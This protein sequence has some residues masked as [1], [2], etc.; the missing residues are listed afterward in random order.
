M[1]IYP[2]IETSK[3]NEEGF[4]IVKNVFTAK[5]IDE[6]RIAVYNNS[7]IDELNKMGR[8]EA[9]VIYGIGDFLGKNGLNH[10]IFD[11][12][13]IT[14]FKKTLG[15]NLVYFGD[16]NYQIGGRFTGFHRDM[17]N[18]KNYT[19]AEWQGDYTLARMGIYLQ[20][21]SI[22]SGGLKIRIGSHKNPTGKPV[23][24][25]TEI[26]DV[27]CW[28]MRTLH[29]GNAVRLKFFPN[30][31]IFNTVGKEKIVPLFMQK[32]HQKERLALFL[33]FAIPSIHYER[34]KVDT[35]KE[36]S[37]QQTLSNSKFN[38]DEAFNKAK[39]KGVLLDKLHP[40]YGIGNN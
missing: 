40:N 36:D 33:S 27:V 23:F 8:K 16:S 12:R 10:L 28:N 34:F 2:T 3:F 30:L 24:C 13:I 32:S 35:I 7:K 38:F 22:H 15:E 9:D 39:S 11:D 26:G 5:E 1:S 17:H 18:S 6:L 14:I 25:N 37:F 31:S 20:D 4:L 29:S 19:A 21:H